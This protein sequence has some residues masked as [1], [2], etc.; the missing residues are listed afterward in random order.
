MLYL[1]NAPLSKH[2]RTV[3]IVR[4]HLF[5]RCTTESNAPFNNI[6]VSYSPIEYSYNWLAAVCGPH[7]DSNNKRVARGK[8]RSAKFSLDLESKLS[9]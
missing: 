6:G 3:D 9:C 5:I 4:S 2:K 7:A 8:A 1:S